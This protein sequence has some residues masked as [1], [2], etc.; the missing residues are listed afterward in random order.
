M[1]PGAELMPFTPLI[2]LNCQPH[3]TPQP[4]AMQLAEYRVLGLEKG[5]W[6]GRA[7][8]ARLG[9]RGWSPGAASP[10]PQ[11]PDGHPAPP[12]AALAVA[13]GEEH[14]WHLSTK[15][16]RLGHVGAVPAWAALAALLGGF[17]TPCL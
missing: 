8:L 11:G 2:F 3:L 13:A 12:R 16:W 6:L 7:W 10:A 1:L 4:F 15:A 17:R 14:W 5:L 9:W